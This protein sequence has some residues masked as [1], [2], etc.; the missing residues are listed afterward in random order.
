MRRATLV[1][2][3]V[4]SLLGAVG[5]AAPGT[6]RFSDIARDAGITFRHAASKTP[7]KFLPETMGGGVAL[8]DYDGDGRLD[9]FFTNGAAI[10]EGMT[11]TRAPDK[12]D[13]RFWN[14]LYRQN[15]DGRFD[16]VTARAGVAG[17]RYDFGVAAGDIDNDGDPDLYVTGYGGNT[18]YRNQGDGTFTD[19]S[20]AAGVTASG[21]SSSAA[22]VDYD[23]DGWLDLFVC[24]Y[25]TWTWDANVP[26]PT[27]DGAGRAYCHPRQF[28]AVTNLLFRNNGD[29]TFKDVSTQSGIASLEG[30]ALGV[31]IDD[32]DADG[33]VDIFVAND[34]MRQFLFRNLG[35]GT[36]A[37]VA[38]AAGVAFDE[39]GRSFAGMGTD[40][41]DYDNDGRPDLIVTTL[42]LE[43][44]ALFRNEGPDGF[45]YATHVSG[46]GRAT[47][48]ASGWGTR[49][50]DVDND[51]DQ[52]LFVAQGHVLDTVSKARQGYDYEQPPLLLR[53]DGGRFTDVSGDMG[54]PF[55]DVGA[56][57]GA[58]I[59]DLDNDGD[60]D[61]VVSN[62]DGEPAVLRNDGDNGRSLRVRLH[63]MRSNRNGIGAIVV[64]T[65]AAGRT[66]RAIAST[67]SSY[68]SASDGRVHF[69]L[70]ASTATRLEVHWPSGI[71]QTV[72]PLPPHGQVDVEEPQTAGRREF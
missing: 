56:G 67:A 31:A 15:G 11:S 45:S 49:F 72:A 16:D 17:H 52:D 48:R 69:G 9:V 24:R 53:N 26:C 42:S 51:G 65:D 12:R 62:L 36:F 68:Q 46:V 66:Q 28:P 57:R 10:D 13:P 70:G 27:A 50:L 32:Y 64:V 37:E 59:G 18:L 40:F 43:R 14:R 20:A 35:D 29:G 44:Y 39:D 8:L 3:V 2:S 34:S 25:L 21:W 38:V 33:R 4:V 47:A 6:Q 55:L 61:L 63:G 54:P 41:G 58:A 5:G 30:K 19:V 23:R 1:A 60:L 7:V 22:F 71:T